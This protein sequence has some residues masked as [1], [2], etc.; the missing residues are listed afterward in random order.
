MGAIRRARIARARAAVYQLGEPA[1]QPCNPLEANAPYT[2]IAGGRVAEQKLEGAVHISA[3][4]VPTLVSALRG[5]VSSLTDSIS[6]TTIRRN[7]SSSSSGD[8][9]T[10]SS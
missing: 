3:Q 8:S 7:R 6:S 9:K 2:D 10:N 5:T 4:F 1:C